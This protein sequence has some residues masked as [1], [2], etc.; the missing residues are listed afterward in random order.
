MINNNDNNNSNSDNINNNNNDNNNN[1]GD[2]NNDNNNNDCYR[3]LENASRL[4][5]LPQL[6]RVM[7][8]VRL[9]QRAVKNA[10]VR[11]MHCARHANCSSPAKGR[12]ECHCPGY[13]LCFMVGR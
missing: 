1:N 5:L 4:R 3:T 7:Q 13:A 2:S 6:E 9:P 10:I 8:T 11:V 12:K